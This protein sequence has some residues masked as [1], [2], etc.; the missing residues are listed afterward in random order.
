MPS[1]EDTRRQSAERARALLAMLDIQPSP[2]VEAQ[3]LS[4][5]YALQARR[6]SHPAP[7]A[8]PLPSRRPSRGWRR[9]CGHVRPPSRLPGPR[10]V[11][12]G[13]VIASAVLL[14]CVS[15][16]MLPAALPE[17]TRQV[18]TTLQYDTAPI[19]ER[20]DSSGSSTAI[21]RP[22]RRDVR[23]SASPG[24]KT[25][26]RQ[27]MSRLLRAEPQ[28]PGTRIMGSLFLRLY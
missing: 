12:C 25:L 26:T 10:T 1:S 8:R 17:G 2:D 14:W 11:A 28:A 4:R 7:Y 22:A 23:G 13:L 27:L 15:T 20:L 16:K 21:H 5:V 24:Q 6:A 19:G 9:G 3:V 18:Y